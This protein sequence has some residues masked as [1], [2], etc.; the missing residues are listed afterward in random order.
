VTDW[1]TPEA[2]RLQVRR[3]WDRGE[4]LAGMVTRQPVF[5]RR[6][7]L[8]RPSSSEL[9]E[10]F[11]EARTWGGQ[12]REMH[13]IRLEL[14]EFKHRV[15]G[16]NTVPHGAWIDTAA[17][18]SALIGMQQMFERFMQLADMTRSRQPLLVD[19]LA[20]HAIKALAFEKDWEFLLDI[21]AWIQAHPRP[22]IYLR[23]LDLPGIDSKFVENRRGVIGELLD[24]A[25]PDAAIDATAVGVAEFARRFGFR[26]KP[27]RIR[28]RLLDAACNLLSGNENQD[29]TLDAPSFARLQTGVTDV[30][31]TE[32]EV[33]FLA[34]PAVKGSM[35][36]FGAGYGF[37]ALGNAEWLKQCRLHYWGDID[38]HAFAIL[39]ELRKHFSHTESFLMDRH[40]LLRFRALWGD[41]ERPANRDLK[42]LTAD[43]A[44]IYDD[45][46]D[47]RIRRNLRLEQ[48]RIS[49]GWLVTA[50]RERGLLGAE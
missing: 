50:L 15:L 28:F 18:A 2:L 25:L 30:F 6:L 16:L 38:T 13:H 4:I 14:R 39:D 41:E 19:W 31:I 29:V 46:R 3:W 21:V 47:G 1:T 40:T 12:L 37:S 27:E 48:E 8:K 11:D 42:R 45:L 34:F 24:I 22:G 5:P 17:D 23:Q 20:G 33:N 9:L 44:S 32:N 36:I 49:Y 10:R 26:D 43:E 35:V 7:T